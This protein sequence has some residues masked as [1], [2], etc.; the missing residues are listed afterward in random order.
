MADKEYPI[1]KLSAVGPG[2]ISAQT[3]VKAHFTGGFSGVSV[4]DSRTI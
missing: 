2:L 1:K 3:G 4:D